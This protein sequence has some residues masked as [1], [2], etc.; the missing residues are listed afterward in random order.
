MEQSRRHETVLSKVVERLHLS[1]H[2]R[3][4][5][6]FV[7][8]VMIHPKGIIHRPPADQFDI[9]HVIKADQFATWHNHHIDAMRP[10]AAMLGLFNI[11]GRQTVREWGEKLKAVHRPVDPLALPSFMKPQPVASAPS[12]SP[13]VTPAVAPVSAPAA[14]ATEEQ[15]MPIGGPQ[16]CA[17]CGKSLTE[18]VAQYCRTH[19]E[20]LG[21]RWL[22]FDHQPR[23]A[24]P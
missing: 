3:S 5:P 13:L 9:S 16:Q 24:R 11:H 22:C 4:T 2:W 12:S 20:R 1:S 7:H 14:S 15:A 6:K 17:V 21:H 18:K 19:A 23:T 10:W 8:V